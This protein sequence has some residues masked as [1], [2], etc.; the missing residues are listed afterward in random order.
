MGELEGMT[1]EGYVAYVRAKMW[2]KTHQHVVKERARREAE[3]AGRKK[4]EEE[5]RRWEEGVEEAL[6]RGEERRRGKRWRGAWEG[7]V[8]GWEGMVQGGGEGRALRGRIPWPVLSGRWEDVGK[9]EVERFFG[10]AV[11]YAGVGEGGLGALLKVER[12]RWHPDKMQQRAGKEG[13]DGETMKMITAAFQV[14]D[15]MWS[16]TKSA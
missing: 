8:R 16:E 9:D 5:G 3:R 6:R 1:D 12:V 2:E 4:L 15:R 7:Y 14:I 10:H 11:Q 13:V